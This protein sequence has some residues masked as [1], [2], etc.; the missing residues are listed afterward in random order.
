MRL[1]ALLLH[2]ALA[3]T[4]LGGV[5]TWLTAESRRVTLAPG[6][7]VDAGLS[8]PL[9]LD[10]FVTVTYPASRVPRDY[11]SHLS[12]GGRSFTVSVNRPAE[13]DGHTIRQDAFDSLGR[14]TVE[15]ARDPWGIPLVYAGYT[16]FVIAGLAMLADPRGRFR[17]LVA[18]ALLLC[19]VGASATPLPGIDADRARLMG[20]R[21][22]MWQGR[23]APF[24]TA[25]R[26]FCRELTGSESPGG[27]PPEQLMASLALYPDRWRRARIIAVD[28]RLADSL[29]LPARHASVADLF[30]SDGTYRLR[31][32][33][34][35]DAALDEAVLEA[36]SRRELIDAL[37]RGELLRPADVPLTRTLRL[38]LWLEVAYNSVPFLPVF[39]AG[40]LLLGL[41]GFMPRA[42]RPLVPA[43]T[44]LALWQTVGW[45]MRWAAYGNVPLA[46]AGET[47][48]F[49]SAALTVLALVT[50]R[51]RPALLAGAI[52]AAGFAGLGG[53]IDLR[54][55]V[56]VPLMPVLRSPWLSV[57]VTLVMLAYAL[58]ALTFVASVTA[59]AR[60]SRAASLRRFVTALLY[61]AL[62]LL[63]AGIITGSVWAQT[64]WGRYWS[65]D[66]K[67][68]WALVTLCVYALPLHRVG[69]RRFHALTVAAFACVLFTYFGVNLLDSLHAYR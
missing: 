69:R 9:R 10:S 31:A 49:L 20:M 62:L 6:E 21:P 4:A 39:F 12:M 41:V 17:K 36:D 26:S 35:I 55:D 48:V 8:A 51:R 52:L 5:A 53:W 56:P 45:G 59:L 3:L 42:R 60:P 28:S 38:R 67:E 30:A 54:H 66:P 29:G 1:P 44:A 14:S 63:G 57:H 7:S 58:L 25:A 64:S 13:A 2:L 65:W 16:L 43:A 47:L 19:A 22:V 15:L 32:L 24:N 33:Y 40:A 34:G 18:P 27:R 50:C 68:T 61:P 11:V 37:Q 46:N 23:V